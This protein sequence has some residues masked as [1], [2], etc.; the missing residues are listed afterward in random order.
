MASTP[1]L[2]KAVGYVR[3]S[4]VAGRDKANGG[5]SFVSP[6]LQRAKI[7]ELARRNDCRIVAWF[8]DLDQSGRKSNRPEWQAALEYVE[9]GRAD[10]VIVAR[11][12]RFARKVKH[13]LEAVDR[14]QERDCPTPGELI[15][16]DV[17]A[18][19][20]SLMGRMVRMLITFMAEWEVEVLSE[21]LAEAKALAM[22]K[23]IKIAKKPPPGYK[24]NGE[25][26]YVIDPAVA[27][28]VVEVFEARADGASWSELVALWFER[29][30][31]RRTRQSF[32]GMLANRT[33][34]GEIWYGDEC[35]PRE[36]WHDP[37][38][39]EAQF[40]A[41]QSKH[42]RAPRPSRSEGGSLLAGILTCGSCGDPMT[43]GSIGH[44]K[45]GRYRC[46]RSSSKT[47]C[48][49]PVQV[50]ATLAD[51]VVE[52]LFRDWATPR[53]YNGETD[54]DG[55]LAAALDKLARAKS[56]VESYTT[57]VAALGDPELFAKGLALRVREVEHAQD[58]VD[59]IRGSG[60][61]ETVQAS[62]LEVWD[63]PDTT[64]ADRRKLLALAIDRA[65]VHAPEGRS[66]RGVSFESR[67]E[68]VFRD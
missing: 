16:G 34:L 63:A 29:T 37:I 51:P 47:P 7:E 49:K 26:K 6:D 28:V 39:T 59:D 14:L 3:V 11:M 33:Y 57:A 24:R 62:A 23:G 4:R 42:V 44:G 64:L 15:A 36:L 45:G 5:D 43:H 61:I 56:E 68:V 30:G 52:K 13:M 60:R 35:A 32:A 18:D 12:S 46:N 53:T 66:A 19:M 65:V 27:P 41:A 9:A 10:V 8:T 17:P 54:G 58:A 31:E 55:G 25:R 67:S 21:H 20:N 50:M 40:E 22:S 48:P 1:K 2:R 38:V